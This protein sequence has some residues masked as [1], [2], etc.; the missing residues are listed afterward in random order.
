MCLRDGQYLEIE[1]PET[2]VPLAGMS[3]RALEIGAARLVLGMEVPTST[4]FIGNE[5]QAIVL[6]DVLNKACIRLNR[7]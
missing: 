7:P 6:R 4:S 1:S 2:E 5:G 3:I